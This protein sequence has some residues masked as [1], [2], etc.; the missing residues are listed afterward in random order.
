MV[1][2]QAGQTDAITF[3][4]ARAGK[5]LIAVEGQA[6]GTQ[7]T[8]SSQQNRAPSAGSNQLTVQKRQPTFTAPIPEIPSEQI[9]ATI[10]TTVILQGRNDVPPPHPRLRVPLTVTLTIPGESSPRYSF[11]PTTDEYGRFSMTGI[12]TGSYEVR[13][14]KATTLQ[15]LLTD[16]FVAGSNNLDVGILYEGDA[17][18]NNYVNILDFSILASAFGTC[19]GEPDFEPRADFN[20]DGCITILDFSLLA[21]NFGQGGSQEPAEEL[22]TSQASMNGAAL[23]PERAFGRQAQGAALLVEALTNTVNV[24]D[25]FTATVLVQ[26]DNQ[27]IDGTQISLNFDPA[28]VEVEHLSGGNRLPLELLNQ[29][30]NSNGTIDFAAGSLVD[31]PSGA[32]IELLHIQFKA[33]AAT[34]SMTLAFQFDPPRES[35]ITFGGSS[36]LSTHTNGTIIVQPAPT[37]ITLNRFDAANW[38][39]LSF[40]RALLLT[41]TAIMSL[42]IGW[43]YV[44][45]EE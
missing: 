12:D 25:I 35:D 32:A 2:V 1:S 41:L 39:P 28:A 11:T 8:I 24:G 33:L 6:T 37:A 14:K 34:E 16:D 23:V 42:L 29:F 17:N 22:A 13:V 15:K 40:I 18:N 9:P 7:Y 26:A 30:D 31:F 4:S 21:S 10:A 19:E 20:G 5:Y 44:A 45:F 43:R 36:V 27:A 3:D 38:E